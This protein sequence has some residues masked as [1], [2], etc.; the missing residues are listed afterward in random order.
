MFN[1]MSFQLIHTSGSPCND[2][3]LFSSFQQI[4]SLGS[5]LHI[6]IIARTEYN[7][8]GTGITGSGNTL[9]H[10][11]ETVVVDNPVSGTREEVARELRT[12]QTHRQVSDSE[13]K[14]LRSLATFF[15]SQSERIELLRQS[16]YHQ[17]FEF[18][19]IYA[20]TT[21]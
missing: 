2:K 9:L 7:H 12:G 14:D 15:G 17:W 10:S 11:R 1:S 8:I 16:P 4:E 18:G 19:F 3:D 13:H 6:L 5:I 21:A 20:A